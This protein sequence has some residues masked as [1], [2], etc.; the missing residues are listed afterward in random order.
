MNELTNIDLMLEAGI[1]GDEIQIHDGDNIV[2]VTEANFDK[3]V[4]TIQNDLQHTT[5]TE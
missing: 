3:I 4:S 5:P 2:T 1:V